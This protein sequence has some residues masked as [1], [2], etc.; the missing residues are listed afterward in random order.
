MIV[1]EC[2][3]NCMR[4][5]L[6]LCGATGVIVSIFSFFVFQNHVDLGRGHQA[7]QP[8]LWLSPTPSPPSNVC[9]CSSLLN[10]LCTGLRACHVSVIVFGSVALGLYLFT[11]QLCTDTYSSHVWFE[12]RLIL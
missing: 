12:R 9:V 7:Q 5:G 3:V 11:T 10:E 1:N 6:P 8:S 2:S 4:A